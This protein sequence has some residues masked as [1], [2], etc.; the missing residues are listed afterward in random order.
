MEDWAEVEAICGH[1]R[2]STVDKWTKNRVKKSGHFQFS[3]VDKWTENRVKKKLLQQGQEHLLH[4]IQTWKVA[5]ASR[6][7][8]RNEPRNGR[9][10]AASDL[11][12]R[13][14]DWPRNGSNIMLTA[15]RTPHRHNHAAA[16]PQLDHYR[17]L[18]GH[19]HSQLLTWA[20]LFKFQNFTPKNVASMHEV[21]NKIYLQNFLHGWVVNREMNLINLINP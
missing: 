21:L 5:G 4:S 20:T 13:G 16:K 18:D 6:S 15:H 14:E 9:S 11:L 8:P 2:F 10:S 19:E 1:F 12:F 7:S 17:L 3:T